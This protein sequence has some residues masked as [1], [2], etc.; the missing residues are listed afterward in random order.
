[1]NDTLTI[2]DE[3]AAAIAAYI[4]PNIKQYIKDN[5]QE[6]RTW[7]KEQSYDKAVK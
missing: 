5:E 6:Y 3:Q 4:Y 2:S 1:M 7:L